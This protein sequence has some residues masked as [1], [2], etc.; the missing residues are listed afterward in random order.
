MDS[1]EKKELIG[2]LYSYFTYETMHI[3]VK[4]CW[5]NKNKLIL[6]IENEWFIVTYGIF[7]PQKRQITTAF[8]SHLTL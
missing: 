7:S 8:T 5:K 2:I 3:F 6:Q 1:Q 4:I